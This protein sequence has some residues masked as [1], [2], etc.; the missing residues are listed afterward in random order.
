[1]RSERTLA[2][3][4][5]NVAETPELSV[6]GPEIIY[7]LKTLM[8]LEYSDVE[9]LCRQKGEY[10]RRASQRWQEWGVRAES[11]W[12]NEPI[13][14]PPSRCRARETSNLTHPSIDDALSF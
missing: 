6:I 11:S 14:L 12:W 13:L 3:V 2:D 4:D 1:M 10:G 9:S 8:S 7:L 5:S